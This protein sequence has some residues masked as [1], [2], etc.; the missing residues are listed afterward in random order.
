MALQG[1]A[2]WAK[3]RVASR[4]AK[5]FSLFSLR[6]MWPEMFAPSDFPKA[7]STKQANLKGQ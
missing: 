3:T 1:F 7:A 2:I 6:G 4:S 5:R